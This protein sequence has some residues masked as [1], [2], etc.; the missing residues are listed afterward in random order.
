VDACG[1]GGSAAGLPYLAAAGGPATILGIVFY[2]PKRAALLI[3]T[4]AGVFTR[5]K[6]RRAASVKIVEALCRGEPHPPR[7]WRSRR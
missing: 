5:D 4:V 7:L 2:A 6:E 1:A 3:A